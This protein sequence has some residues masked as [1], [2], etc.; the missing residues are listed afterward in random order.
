[1][2]KESKKKILFGKVASGKNGVLP[3]MAHWN[4]DS[5]CRI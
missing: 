5:G 4:N 3:L 1:M 2:S